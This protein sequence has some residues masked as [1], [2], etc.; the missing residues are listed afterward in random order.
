M[1]HL[2][3]HLNRTIRLLLIGLLVISASQAYAATLKLRIMETT[4]LHVHMVNYDYYKDKEDHTFGLA[5]TATLIKNARNEVVNS[6]LFDNGDLLQG[7]PLGD[8]IAKGKSFKE[9]DIHPVFKA[10]NL[11]NY[12]AGNLGNHEFNY[13]LDF[14]Q[15]SLAGAAFPYVSANVFV[16]DGDKNPDNDENFFKPYLI[17]DKQLEDTNGNSHKIKIGVIGFVTPQIMQWDRH[18]LTK[19]V[20]TKD[21]VLTAKQFIPKMKAEG[22]DVIIVLSH[23]GLGGDQST[24]MEENA[25]YQ[26]S[27]IAGIDVIL[28]G[29]SHRVFPGKGFD[30]IK[31]VDNTK[32]TINGIPA[33]MP[34]S[35]GSHL[36]VIDLTLEKK[37]ASWIVASSQS[38]ARAIYKSKG[39]EKIPL[40]DADKSIIEAVKMEHEGTIKFVRRSVG[41][42]TAPI[43]SYFALVADDPSIQIVT[44]A[45][46]WYVEQL[47][48]GTEYNGLPILSAGA[49]FKA[50]GR[51]GAGYYTD[52]P[53][54]DIAIKNVADL[55]IYPNTLQVVLINGEQV[56][57]W[58]EMSATMFN[59]IDPNKSGEQELINPDFPSYNF[60]VIDGVTYE[61]DVTQPQR[62]AN[63]KGLVNPDAHRIK[64]LKFDGKPVEKSD[65]FLVA[66]NNYRAAGGGNFPGLDGSTI[67]IEAPQTNRQVLVDYIFQKKTINPSA[68]NNWKFSPINAK[69]FVVFESSPSAKQYAASSNSFNFIKVKESG[70]ANYAI[71][72]N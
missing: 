69:V 4:D 14:L 66:T 58:L 70:F 31:G 64:N 24:G 19:R 32:G 43:T 34:G 17:L 1:R 29:H 23:S 35:W 55:Y 37:G 27:K 15:K 51:G 68:D 63:K 45:Q 54:G 26:L 11:L 33:V 47:V 42:T 56:R 44:N 41:K 71:D 6:L 48:Q 61:I 8:F 2:I 21:I 49:P 16:D 36:G 50:G 40:V 25:S 65:R 52:V 12:D 10:M 9:G 28:F 62:Y 22:A 46:K 72:M 30:E 67:V 39:R 20:I 7:N 59:Q 3:R 13:G 5:I 53:A 60:D 57:E 38:E 18:H